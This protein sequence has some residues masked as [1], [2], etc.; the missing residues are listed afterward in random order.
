MDQEQENQYTQSVHNTIRPAFGARV[1]DRDHVFID[2]GRGPQVE[3][4]VGGG[5]QPTIEQIA[6]QSH[7]GGAFRVFL[8]GIEIVDEEDIPAKVEAGMRIALT[9]YDKPG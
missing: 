2:T 4:A 6:D 8:N 9:A 5:F 7:Y 1:I 3:V